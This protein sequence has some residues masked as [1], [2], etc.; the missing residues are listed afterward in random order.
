MPEGERIES[1]QAVYTKYTSLADLKGLDERLRA[2]KEARLPKDEYQQIWTWIG[3]KESAGDDFYERKD[4]KQYE[5]EQRVAELDREKAYALA[6]EEERAQISY[7]G[8]PWSKEQAVGELAAGERVE[9]LG[10][11]YTKFSSLDELS[12]LDARIEEGTEGRLPKA[13]YQKIQNWILAKDSFGDGYHER[14]DREKWEAKQRDYAKDWDSLRRSSQGERPKDRPEEWSKQWAIEQLPCDE[15]VFSQGRM[16]T[17]FSSLDAL[18]DLDEK[19]NA[20]D[21]KALPIDESL[22]LWSWI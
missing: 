22:L 20:R 6:K 17:K 11:V 9:Y 19:L 5:W 2:G 1:G 13:E 10:K 21:C 16:Y 14:K 18:K 3:T 8:K 7:W 12:A 15:M 4:K